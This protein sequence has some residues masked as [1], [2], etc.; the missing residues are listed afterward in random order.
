MGQE[1]Q[2]QT[3]PCKI[4]CGVLLLV[5]GSCVT[6]LVLRAGLA[7]VIIAADSRP[8]ISCNAKMSMGLRTLLFSRTSTLQIKLDYSCLITSKYVS[9][10][11]KIS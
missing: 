2:R 7:T 11:F 8:D 5:R 6:T 9:A 4:S 10:Y 3:V 1:D